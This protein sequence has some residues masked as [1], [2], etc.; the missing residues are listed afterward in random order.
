LDGALGIA[1]GARGTGR[2][3]AHYEPRTNIINITR[4]KGGRHAAIPK[5][6]RF[7]NTGGVGAFAHEYGHFLDFFFGS[8]IEVDKSVYSLTNGSST[9]ARMIQYNKTSQPIRCLVEELLKVA[10]WHPTKKEP[11]KYIQRIQHFS[12]RSYYVERT[13]IFARLFEQYIGYKLKALKIQNS[14]LAQTKYHSHIYMTAAELKKVVPI[15]DKIL[16]R[17]RLAF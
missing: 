6:I 4:Y 15:F 10:Y 5:E 16:V 7:V 11:S 3:L 13:E 2:A 1:F 17:M 12:K 9:N 8:K 14:F